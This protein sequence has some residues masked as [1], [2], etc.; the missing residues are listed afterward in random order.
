MRVADVLNLRAW[1]QITLLQMDKTSIANHIN[2]AGR[3][4]H[5]FWECVARVES[6]AEANGMRFFLWTASI[7]IRRDCSAYCS[8]DLLQE[9]ARW[10]DVFYL[11]SDDVSRYIRFR[12]H[13]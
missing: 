11:S 7:C 1:T 6:E 9:W 12:S 10:L 2:V 4:R 13:I 5:G 3:V 8:F